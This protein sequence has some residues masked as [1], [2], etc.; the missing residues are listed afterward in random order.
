[1]ESLRLNID[2]LFIKYPLSATWNMIN[3]MIK[4]KFDYIHKMI[5][6]HSI[7]IASCY[8]SDSQSGL[9]SNIGDL[10][11]INGYL[12]AMFMEYVRNICLCNTILIYMSKYRSYFD[13]VAISFA[14]SL[15]RRLLNYHLLSFTKSSP[16]IIYCGIILEES[17]VFF[18]NHSPNN[19]AQVF[20][21][22]NDFVK[23]IITI[24]QQHDELLILMK[25]NLLFTGYYSHREYFLNK[26]IDN[27]FSCFINYHQKY[28]VHFENILQ[29]C[30]QL[31]VNS[32][33]I[34]FVNFDK[35]KYFYQK[36]VSHHDIPYIFSNG[37]S[38]DHSR[39]IS[40][41]LFFFFC[42]RYNLL[43]NLSTTCSLLNNFYWNPKIYCFSL[44]LLVEVL[45]LGINM[46]NRSKNLSFLCHKDVLLYFR[47]NGLM[48]QV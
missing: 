36:F 7:S 5:K 3:E 18:N 13:A 19:F 31:Y 47:S 16:T 17:N 45:N 4:L 12:F 34:L 10:F 20:C 33:R 26:S 30:N 28:C 14:T 43:L 25:R 9:C 21:S 39:N 29:L 22:N 32:H 35:G 48:Y 46:S 24:Y 37:N 23:N 27:I 15:P 2:D 41:K 42:L 1:M 38:F 44:P 40:L 11:L 6:S 8:L